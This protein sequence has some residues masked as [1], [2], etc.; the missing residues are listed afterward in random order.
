VRIALLSDYPVDP[1][2]I[3]GGVQAVAYH[4]AEGLAQHDDL[5]LHVVHSSRAVSADSVSR[6]G[7]LTVH[8]LAP[9]GHGS[10]PNF[11]AAVFRCSRVLEAIKPDLAHAHTSQY[12]LAATRAAVPTIY[13]IHGIPHRMLRYVRGPR[14]LCAAMV[15]ALFDRLA[16]RR[17]GDIVAISP[18]VEA[19]YRNLTKARFHRAENLVPDRWFNTVIKEVQGRI[20]FAGTVAYHKGLHS[21]AQGF[22]QLTSTVPEAHLHVAG[23]IDDPRYMKR[24]RRMLDAP[25]LNDRLTFLGPLDGSEMLREYSECALLVLPSL[26]E[27]APLAVLEAMAAARPVVATR[28]GGVPDLVKDGVT[29]LLVEPGDSSGLSD[30]MGRLLSDSD[31]R[32]QMG[33]RGQEVAQARFRRDSVVTRHRQIYEEVLKTRELRR[34][35]CSSR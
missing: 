16:I 2:R 33:R 23:R 13:T 8:R 28:V 11:V 3:Y 29:G 12:A 31:L 20:L 30:R 14:R 4:L 35:A 9:P 7:R 15:P 27:T 26:C 24:I 32:V 5:D 10:M 34:Q 25:Q 18:Y 17:V 19:A 1:D 22:S 21:L 6:E